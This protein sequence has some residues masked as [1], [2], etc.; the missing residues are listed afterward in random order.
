MPIRIYALAKELQIDSKELVV[1]CTKAGITGK[2]SALASLDDAEAEKVKAFISGA[3]KKAAGDKG[4]RPSSASDPA[5]PTRYTRDDYIAPATSGKVK[6]ISVSRPSAPTPETTPVSEPEPGVEV[7]AETE[8]A[9]AGET[10][11]EPPETEREV[12][13]VGE[14][15]GGPGAAAEAPPE[16]ADEAPSAPAET[17]PEVR[18]TPRKPRE[19][20]RATP[21]TPSTPS[22]PSSGA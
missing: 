12:A 14:P 20:P 15:E 16:P 5:E 18:R 22:P 7:A 2:G 21:K 8:V 10:L 19:I 17:R 9:A 1:I 6:V 11:S 4:R 13:P 3:K